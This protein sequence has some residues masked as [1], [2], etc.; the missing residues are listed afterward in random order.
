VTALP[1]LIQFPYSHYN[2]KARWA[3]DWKRIPHVRTDLLPG[4]HAPFVRRLTGQ[5]QTPLLRLDGRLLHGSARILAELERHQPEPPLYPKDPALRA[6]ALEIERFFDEEIGPRVRRGLFAALLE[7]P[8]YIA[9]I[10][11]SQRHPI[12]RALYRAAMPIARGLMR[13]GMG[14][15]DAASI[16][17]GHEGTRRGLDFVAREA[18]ADGHLVGGAVSVAD[19]AAAALL[20]PA[21]MPE[22]SPMCLPR[23]RPAALDAWLAGF[24]AH[25]GAD[26]VRDRYARYRPPC[27]AVG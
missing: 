12:V 2:E 5:T 24:A 25:P 15:T 6:R 18:G 20:A 9:H 19:L 21:V 10:F 17:D 27:A 22:G 14:I 8:G 26:W 13:K 11:S 4:P 23:P 7:T 3:L 1:E 16:R